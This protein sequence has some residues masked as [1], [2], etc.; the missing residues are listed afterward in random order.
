MAVHIPAVKKATD[1]LFESGHAA[2]DATLYGTTL[3]QREPSLHL[4]HPAG[5]GGREVEGEART[6][7]Q[8][9]I[10]ERV[11]VGVVVVEHQVDLLG[12][13]APVEDAQESEKLLAP[14]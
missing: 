4:I 11:F 1:R 2:E 12:G 10:D 3:E 14:V 9:R 7:C 13:I 8:P 6:L 5:T